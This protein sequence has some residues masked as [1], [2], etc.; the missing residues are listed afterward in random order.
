MRADV[1]LENDW[2]YEPA[3]G[4]L[5]YDISIAGKDTVTFKASGVG[6]YQHARWHRVM[7]SGPV[8][9]AAVRY[10]VPYF[11]RSRIVSNYD[12]AIHIPEL[13]LADEARRLAAADTGPMGAAFITPYMPTTGGRGGYR[14]APPLDGSLSSVA[15]RPCAGRY[16]GQ[17]RR[18]RRYPDPLSRPADGSTG[19]HRPSSRNCPVFS[20]SRGAWMVCRL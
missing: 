1:V 16:A 13:T 15:R 20:A 7:W 4:N 6:L 19:Q 3:P 11:V 14:T 17:C 5:D 12:T 2:T 18:L 9:I 8:P 10:D